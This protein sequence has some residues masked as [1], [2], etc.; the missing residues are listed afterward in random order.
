MITFVSVV[1]K[2]FGLA[3]DF[4]L[5]W[6]FLIITG[7]LFLLSKSS[8]CQEPEG[9][10]VFEGLC[11]AHCEGF[12]LGDVDRKIH[13]VL[14]FL[15]VFINV[16][17]KYLKQDEAER[18][19]VQ[20]KKQ[21]WWNPLVIHII[22]G[23]FTVLP[24]GISGVFGWHSEKL[25]NFIIA[26]S[27][28]HDISIY[29]L[30]NN[31]DGI[32]AIR[33]ANLF[34]AIQKTII[35]LAPITAESKTDLLFFMAFGFMGTRIACTLWYILTA[36]SLPS[37]L[38]D[39]YWYS[40]GLAMAQFYI[41][42]RS[43]QIVGPVVFCSFILAGVICYHKRWNTRYQIA[44]VL[45]QV[46]MLVVYWYLADRNAQITLLFAF[47][48][49]T[50]KMPFWRRQRMSHAVLFAKK[51]KAKKAAEK[52]AAKASKLLDKEEEADSI[53]VDSNVMH[54]KTFSFPESPEPLNC[55]DPLP[56]VYPEPITP[57]RYPMLRRVS[58]LSMMIM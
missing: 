48:M 33:A 9:S 42:A 52:E 53:S 56:V 11:C 24:A 34:L 46:T 20:M 41:F 2:K 1:S 15:G 29:G 44:F 32:W 17:P 31:H 10:L 18:H 55:V 35:A 6:A 30:L 27:L 3:F 21:R 14:A 4:A 19:L 39:E 5:S 57:R 51:E 25:M 38:I 8:A 43:W 23:I 47:Y 26:S 7:G 28:L 54:E 13:L 22:G 58:N 45:S 37:S 49:V 36:L 40:A 12:R 50:F 16:V